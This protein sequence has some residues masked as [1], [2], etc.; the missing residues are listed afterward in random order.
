MPGAEI[1]IVS[2]TGLVSMALGLA[3]LLVLHQD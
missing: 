2:L 1:L 3:A